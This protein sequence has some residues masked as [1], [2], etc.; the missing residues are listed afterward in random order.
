VDDEVA[1]L[2]TFELIISHAGH[3]VTMFASP[4][5]ALAWLRNNPGKADLVITD[6]TMPELSGIELADQLRDF[7]PAVPVI[8][9]S[10]YTDIADDSPRPNIKLTLCKPVG[11]EALLRAVADAIARH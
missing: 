1:V 11:Y 4:A 2:K 10:G 6:Q 8:L 5:Q 9:I 7:A 3:S